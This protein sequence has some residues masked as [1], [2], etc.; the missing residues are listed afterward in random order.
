LRSKI[1]QNQ[2]IV[3]GKIKED[4]EKEEKKDEKVKKDFPQENIEQILKSIGLAECI[5][6]MKEAEI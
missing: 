6:K 4:E 2:L 3:L 5:A 1:A